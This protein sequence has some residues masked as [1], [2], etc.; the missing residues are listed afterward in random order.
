MA[1]TEDWR[2][3][4]S[5]RDVPYVLSVGMLIAIVYISLNV[6]ADLLVVLLVPK[7][8]TAQ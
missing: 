7:L 2:E 1:D 6:L 5:A 8:R 3:A 4:V